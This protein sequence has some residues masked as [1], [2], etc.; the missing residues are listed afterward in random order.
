MLFR[1]PVQSRIEPG[2]FDKYKVQVMLTSRP[3]SNS[4]SSSRSSSSRSSSGRSN[5]DNVRSSILNI[6][7]TSNQRTLVNQEA[8]RLEPLLQIMF[9]DQITTTLAAQP[10]RELFHAPRPIVHQVTCVRQIR[11]V[12]VMTRASRPVS[13]SSS[14]SRSSSSRS[15][16]SRSSSGRSN[17]RGNN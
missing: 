10:H 13:N 3:V 12:Q 9:E 2:A 7:A 17:S 5:R 8:E 11:E 16:G 15:S 6:T 14:S 4:S 1:E